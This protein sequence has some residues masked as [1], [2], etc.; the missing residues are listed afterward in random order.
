MFII[1]P[2]SL[3]TSEQSTSGIEPPTTALI[4]QSTDTAH[5]E[6]NC[7]NLQL[8]DTSYLN[9]ARQ[10]PP[11]PTWSFQGG[12]NIVELLLGFRAIVRKPI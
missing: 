1:V 11:V 8:R 3:T 9:A 12:G 6:V 7:V 5:Y 2:V 4:D 10:L